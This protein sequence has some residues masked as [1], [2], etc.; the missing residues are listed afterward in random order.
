MYG[1]EN[2]TKIISQTAL[3]IA[4][5][6]IGSYIQIPMFPVPITM[7]TLFVLLAGCI[8]KRYA[9]IPVLLYVI[10]GT[11]GLPVFHQFTSGPGVLLGPT[12][13]YLIGFVAAAAVVGV[14]YEND[15]KLTRIA[16]LFAGTAIIAIFGVLW[17]FVSTSMT[18][19]QA[20]LI[21]VLP[22]IPGDIIKTA[23]AYIIGERINENK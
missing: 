2:R 3:F 23:A 10:L 5:I 21:G 6:S 16:G 18:F 11:I 15:K 7:Q 14:I 12:G 22:F 13:G 8:M 4:L 17:L 19:G 1:D 20:F 9:I